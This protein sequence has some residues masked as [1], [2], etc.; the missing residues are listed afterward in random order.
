MQNTL[1]SPQKSVLVVID[2]QGKLAYLMHDK[3]RLFRH[4]EALIKTAQYLDIPIIFT[5]QAPEKI[6]S[7]V[8]EISHLFPSQVPL[9]K[10][11]FSCC[12]SAT[13]SSAL[14]KLKR[15]QII[16]CGIE[17]HVCVYQTVADLI[18]Q[19]YDL[20]VVADAVSSR[21]NENKD[22]ALARMTALGVDIT[23][24]EMLATEL[25][26]TSKHPKFKNVLS[27]IR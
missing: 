17:T 14:T 4:I 18:R 26:R 5:E 20:Q 19:K 6:G 21:T 1:F 11:T 27:L 23:S 9:I 22:I 13:F 10:E 12:G 24:T 3:A 16:I 25:L 7:T 15:K 2:V 8:P